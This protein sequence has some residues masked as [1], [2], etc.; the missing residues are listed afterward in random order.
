[1]HSDMSTL[2]DA[3][4]GLVSPEV[5]HD[6]K[7]WDRELE[8][9]FGR[10]WLFLAHES[11]LSEPSS[12]IATMMGATPVIVNRRKDGTLGAFVNACR[13]RGMRMR[14]EEFGTAST[15]TCPYHGWSY[16]ETGALRVV[17][18]EKN[19]G[20]NLDK[21]AWGLIEVAQLDV[22]RGLI[23]ATF[24]ATAPPLLDYLGDMTFYID[25]MWDRLEGG[26]EL[27][28]GVQKWRIKA[29]WKLA[30]EQFASDNYHVFT[31]H[32]SPYRVLDPSG[33]GLPP[34]SSLTG[35]QVTHPNGH[36]SGWFLASDDP[37]DGSVLPAGVR[38]YFE[39]THD[40][41]GARIGATRRDMESHAT[42]F[43][44]FSFLSA[45]IPTARVWH[46]VAPDEVEVWA[47][48]YVNVSA[49][50]EVK[51][52]LRRLSVLTFGVSGIF[53]Q[54]DGDNWAQIQRNLTSPIVRNAPF[55]FQMGLNRTPDT[56][57]ELPGQLGPPIGEMA[58]RGFFGRWQELMNHHGPDWP[59]TEGPFT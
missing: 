4:S 7:V 59:K 14:C 41:I 57:A 5:Y 6:R 48:A 2:V 3:A 24:D 26:A 46:P 39:E 12:F 18:E 23:F 10:S 31:T 1:M 35:N 47:W 42:V 29:N 52:E 32:I 38:Q 49:P 20:G 11:Q 54:D 33:K 28:G 51:D 43:P 13:H 40:A 37:L 44:N 15:F 22:Y 56:D 34:T 16:G 19:Y 30:A 9:V 17:P 21:G 55:S 50:Q 27:I 25:A 53:E 58:S 36:G 45:D 8:R